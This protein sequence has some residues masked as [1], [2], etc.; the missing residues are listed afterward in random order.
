MHLVLE[1]SEVNGPATDQFVDVLDASGELVQTFQGYDEALWLDNAHLVLTTWQ[2]SCDGNGPC[3]T[4]QEHGTSAVAALGEQPVPV[5]TDLAGGV[6]N[7]HGA[8]AFQTDKGMAVWTADG[9]VS[10]SIPGYPRQWSSDGTRLDV[11]HP[12]NDSPGDSWPQIVSWPGLTTLASDE[13]VRYRDGGGAIDQELTRAA[14]WEWSPDTSTP[15]PVNAHIV[16]LDTGKITPL[17]ALPAPLG[18]SAW[19]DNELLVT[20]YPGDGATAYGIDGSALGSWSDLGF[21]IDVVA[22]GTA[23]ALS[24]DEQWPDRVN[25]L[26]GNQVERLTAPG[27]LVGG[28][29]SIVLAPD[30]SKLVVV[31]LS[32]FN[33]ETA[34]LTKLS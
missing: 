31:A 29:Y 23:Y 2:R 3:E 18:R 10:R 20:T 30:G 9:R 32:G 5:A 1:R 26:R 25:V 8:V 27:Q 19:G 17:A 21:E 14:T 11:E 15:T 12:L 13:T 22:G 6:S 7:G 33:Q 4:D 16:N 28:G 24:D 34:Y